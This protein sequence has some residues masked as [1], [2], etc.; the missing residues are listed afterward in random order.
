MDNLLIL[1]GSIEDL[2]SFLSDILVAYFEDTGFNETYTLGFDHPY[3][4]VNLIG[5]KNWPL[6]KIEFEQLDDDQVLM[7][8]MPTPIARTATDQEHFNYF[9]ENLIHQLASNG[10]EPMFLDAHKSISPPV[11]DADE[12]T[13]QMIALFDKLE[14]DDQETLI[15]MAQ[16]LVS[17]R[18]AKGRTRPAEG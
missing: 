15:N 16:F 1:I 9:V 10:Y 5:W 11:I 8:I 17:R 18:T 6:G 4:K 14:T 2:F 13:Q 3:I 7:K 12:E